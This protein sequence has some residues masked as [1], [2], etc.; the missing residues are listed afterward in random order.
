MTT[1]QGCPHAREPMSAWPRC[2]NMKVNGPHVPVVP[3]H[4]RSLRVFQNNQLTRFRE[5][6][7]LQ[8]RIHLLRRQY[9]AEVWPGEIILEEGCYG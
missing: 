9:G 2:K 7:Q 6:V 8:F 5:L 3:H 4:T 1:L